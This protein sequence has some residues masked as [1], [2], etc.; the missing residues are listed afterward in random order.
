MSMRILFVGG[1]NMATALMAGLI[2]EG[3]DA[4]RLSV[5][6]RNE[7]S[8]ER[9]L[10]TWPV[11]VF[12]EMV[13]A[14][15]ETDVVVLAVKPQQLR[16][17]AGQIAPLLDGQL[18]L[19]VAAGVRCSAL[20][21]WLGGYDALVRAMPNTP[22]TI[23]AGIAGLYAMPAVS[24]AQRLKATQI[25]Q[26]AGA[27]VWLEEESALDAVTAV[28]GSGPAYV[29]YFMEAMERA[30]VELGLG[31]DI[32]R[33]LTLATFS[34]ASRL[35]MHSHDAPAVLRERVTS[36]GGTTESALLSMQTADVAGAVIRAIAAAHLRSRELGD[37]LG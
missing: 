19:S 36:P 18:V 6:E 35:A 27:A 15:F 31:A 34:G 7:A 2:R 20:S 9:L 33:Q 37:A 30:A 8:R 21:G 26:A 12:D 4:N 16:E 32:A 22:A 11:R 5:I 24:A 14:A 13:A 10:A 29:F 28:S 3:V 25:M 1:G 17:V 23:G